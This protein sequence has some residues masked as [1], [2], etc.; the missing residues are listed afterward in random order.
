M[1]AILNPFGLLKWLDYKQG[2][3]N[4]RNNPLTGTFLLLRANI[5][6]MNDI[7]PKLISPSSTGNQ[8]IL[9]LKQALSSQKDID[10][11]LVTH[12]QTIVDQILLL[13]SAANS[14]QE[15]IE[16]ISKNEA[17][18]DEKDKKIGANIQTLGRVSN[19]F[20]NEVH[21]IDYMI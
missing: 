6:G 15:L 3:S 14:N 10:A 9:A 8:T 7:S 1:R 19:H 20:Y 21:H 4:D 17:D 18:H 16:K 12:L 5:S 2:V 11:T 13:Q